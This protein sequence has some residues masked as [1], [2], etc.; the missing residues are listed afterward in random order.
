MQNYRGG[1]KTTIEMTTET[2]IERITE[3]KI[4]EEEEVG[5]EKDSIQLILEGMIE[6]AVAVDLD[7]V[8]EPVQ[9]DRIRCYKCR[10]YDHFTN[11]CPNPYTGE[12]EQ[13]QKMYNLDENQTAL[14][15]LAQDSYED[16]IRAG[17]KTL[18]TI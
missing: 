18:W 16:F 10:E 11:D 1:C 15:I 2:N 4:M 6:E 14:Q 5:L 13:I 3:T 7:H 17:N 8:L 12:I 9:I